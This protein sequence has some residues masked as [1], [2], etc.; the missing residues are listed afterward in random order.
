[1]RYLSPIDSHVHL[2]W[3][4]S[5]YI[6]NGM[7]F[8]Q[9]GLRDAHAV[10]L[11][12]MVEMP[13]TTPNLTSQ[14]TIEERIAHL[15]SNN[16]SDIYIG[17]YGGATNDADQIR[18]IAKLA[19]Q[20]RKS[21]GRVKGLKIYFAH[22]TGNM[23]IT[24]EEKQKVFWEQIKSAGFAGNVICHLEDE[25]KYT[26]EFDY[27]NP[28][29]HSLRQTPESELSQA[30]KQIRNAKDYGFTGT[31]ISAHTSN[32]DTID[33]LLKESKTGNLPF[34]IV[35]EMTLHHMLLN[36]DDYSVH[37]NGVKMNPPLR[38]REMQERNLEH[39]LK[40]NV[41]MI[42]TDHAPHDPSRKLDPSNK[43][44]PSGIPGILAWPLGIAV[45]K[46][47]GIDREVLKR[48]IFGNA[49]EILFRGKLNPF[50]VEVKYNPE[51]WAAYGYNPF[52]RIEQ[53]LGLAD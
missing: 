8:L 42:G 46:K 33:Y 2:R 43:S 53:D 13:N 4:E 41:T 3:E 20:S 51:L 47:H 38:S 52:S 11:A 32:P 23:G 35:T 5:K 39:V 22:S 19:K 7:N 18:E 50:E 36:T 25:C 14:K 16:S 37:G 27:R 21:Y 10:G 34:N 1:M 31:L 30:E 6:F 45:L 9:L 40:G 12:A 49:N 29:S 17:I 48:I 26:G 24:E 44:P 15:D 28:A